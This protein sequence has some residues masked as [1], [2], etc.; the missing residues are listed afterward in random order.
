MGTGRPIPVCYT[1]PAR[2]DI[3]G[4]YRYIATDNRLAALAVVAAIKEAVLLLS[5]FPEKS[6]KTRQRGLRALPLSQYPYII[7]CRIRSDELPIVHVLHGARRHPGF[8]E[9]AAA[10]VR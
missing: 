2:S 8:P 4:I 3:D 10:F 6:R 1:A 7:F 5:H 9:E